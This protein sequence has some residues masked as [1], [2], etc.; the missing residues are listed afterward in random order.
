[1]T[2]N[3]G[4]GVITNSA[5]AIGAVLAALCCA[6]TPFIVVALAT[7]R[8]S[9]LRRDAVLWPL[10]LASL[11]VAVWGFW[12]GLQVHRRVGPLV[13]GVVGAIS[14]AAGVIVIHGFPAMQM[15]YAGAILLLG[16]TV[17]NMRARR[18]CGA[19]A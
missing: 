7:L 15:I 8:L 16:A 14:L 5:P 1:M 11:A 18:G 9:F 6:G 12:S 10:M 19:V 2:E 4:A 3:R 13:T 17:W